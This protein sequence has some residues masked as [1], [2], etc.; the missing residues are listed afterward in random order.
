MLARILK[1]PVVREFRKSPLAIGATIIFLAFI[2]AALFGSYLA[3]Y[4]PTKM[5]TAPRQPPS[6]Q[7]WF[8]T[9]QIG[10]DIFSRILV[11]SRTALMVGFISVAIGLG[12][13][14]LIGLVAAYSGG[15]V[16]SVLMRFIDVMLAFPGLLIALAVVSILGPGLRNTMIAIG[17]GGIA[18]YA[19][20]M[21]GEILALMRRDFVL[22]ARAIG[23]SGPRIVVRHLLPL[24]LSTLMVF[25]TAQLARAILSEAGLSFL[26][27]GIQPPTPSWGSMVAASQRYFLNAPF[28]AIFPSLAIMALVIALNLLGD[29]LQDALNPKLRK[30]R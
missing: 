20:L 9:D 27:L 26:G 24:T 14:A 8:G 7:H 5:M 15:W 6:S 4:P 23:A 3:P 11:S 1:S 21:R 29:S 28:M 12:C 22:S 16:D 10:R 25:S 19:R 2:V 30:V 18:R 17:I 13:G